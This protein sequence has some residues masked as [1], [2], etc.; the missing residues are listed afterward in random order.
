[1]PEF[2]PSDSTIPP[3]ESL[4]NI[5]KKRELHIHG[6]NILGICMM[7]GAAKTRL[8]S[9]ES[10]K[11]DRYNNTQTVNKAREIRNIT[12]YLKQVYQALHS[13]QHINR[14]YEELEKELDSTFEKIPKKE[15][16]EPPK[17]DR[18]CFLSIR[19]LKKYKERN[20]YGILGAIIEESISREDGDIPSI[21]R[22]YHELKDESGNKIIAQLEREEQTYKESLLNKLKS[23]TN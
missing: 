15:T 7:L 17:I 1:M 19:L 14:V 23:G 12:S 8:D 21:K 6:Y 2:R 18:I 9:I 5:F 13:G 22:S 16:E 3:L 11:I 4:L 10:P 20:A